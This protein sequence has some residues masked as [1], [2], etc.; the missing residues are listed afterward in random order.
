MRA[1]PHLERG[2]LL[3]CK[4]TGLGWQEAQAMNPAAG[5]RRLRLITETDK[6]RRP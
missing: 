5:L 3:L 6:P 4:K 2:L 1:R